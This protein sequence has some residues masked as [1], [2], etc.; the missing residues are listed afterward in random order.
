MAPSSPGFRWSRATRRRSGFT[1]RWD[2]TAR[3]IA[4][5]I[6]RHRA[7]SV[8]AQEA[9]PQRARQRRHEVEVEIGS[10]LER[11][12]LGIEAAGMDIE[13]IGDGVDQALGTVGLAEDA[14][15]VGKPDLM[16]QGLHAPRARRLAAAAQDLARG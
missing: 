2:S 12:A 15:R 6:A 3:S 4:I 8:P 10:G 9:L 5:T 16:A 1:T 14:A 13:T 11:D 7:R